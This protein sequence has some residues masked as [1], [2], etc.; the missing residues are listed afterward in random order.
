VIRCGQW[1]LQI[2]G[3]TR[4]P[5]EAVPEAAGWPNFLAYLETGRLVEDADLETAGLFIGRWPLQVDGK[6]RMPGEPI[7]EARE[8]PNLSSYLSMRR[9]VLGDAPTAREPAPLVRRTRRPS[10]AAGEAG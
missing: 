5:G 7:P 1:P 9:I 6:T 4:L 2:D 8:W 10:G 3:E